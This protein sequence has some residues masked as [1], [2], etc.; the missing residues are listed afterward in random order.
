MLLLYF[1]SVTLAGYSQ[2]NLRMYFDVTLVV[3]A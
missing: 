1:G 2:Q 3:S